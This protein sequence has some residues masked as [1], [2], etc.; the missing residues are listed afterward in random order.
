MDGHRGRPDGRVDRHEVGELEGRPGRR[1]EHDVDVDEIV[2]AQWRPVPDERLEHR[3][4]DAVRSDLV[5]RVADRPEV[6][7]AGSF[8]IGQISPVMD[9]PH[10][11]GLREPDAEL[12]GV[13]IRGR[14]E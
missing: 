2:E 12:V 7:D 4:V 3:E 6:L 1:C 13:R 11:I 14:I 5:V 8:E 9:D 10:R